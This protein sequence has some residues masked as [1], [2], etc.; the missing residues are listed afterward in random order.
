MDPGKG[1]KLKATGIKHWASSNVGTSIRSGFISLPGG[2]RNPNGRFNSIGSY[3]S[4]WSATG[5]GSTY[6]WKRFMFSRTLNLRRDFNE[7]GFGFSVRCI[8][9]N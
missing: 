7:E 4:W 5:Y 9:D 1:R 2:C 3:S 8:K 6:A